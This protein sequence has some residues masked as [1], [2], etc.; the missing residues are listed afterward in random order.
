MTN[1]QLQADQRL[2]QL[3]TQKY[4]NILWLMGTSEA[5]VF[6]G[7]GLWD[8]KDVNYREVAADPGN[9]FMSRLRAQIAKLQLKSGP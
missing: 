8:E 1:A 4:N 7:S 9:Q 6:K 5:E 2:I 3:L